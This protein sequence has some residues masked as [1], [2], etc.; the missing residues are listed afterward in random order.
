ML[1]N[2]LEDCE[3]SNC[4]CNTVARVHC[5]CSSTLGALSLI[6]PWT[7]SVLILLDVLLNVGAY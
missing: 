6:V 3:L 1:A 5:C 2:Y 4:F 7:D